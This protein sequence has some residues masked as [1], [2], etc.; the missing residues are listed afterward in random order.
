MNRIRL[1]M[2]MFMGLTC[3]FFTLAATPPGSLTPETFSSLQQEAAQQQRPFAVYVQIPQAKA[4]RKMDRSWKDAALS[5]YLDEH[6]LVRQVN[7]L[8][9]Q[10]FI[11]DYQVQRFPT[12]LI[13]S[14]EGKI[15]G[16]TEGYVEPATLERIFRKHVV[17]LLQR[18][19]LQAL[20]VLTV[21]LSPLSAPQPASTPAKERPL[22]E[23]RPALSPVPGYEAHALP[24]QSEEAHGVLVGVHRSKQALDRQLKRLNRIWR[25]PLWVF[26]EQANEMEVY[27]VVV[28]HYADPQ[29][30]ARFAAGLQETADWPAEVLRLPGGAR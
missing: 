6:Y 11:H 15:M 5:A 18:K 25:G 9:E 14:P 30:A 27:K 16:R 10:E 4:C 2:A 21:D 7:A 17:R 26:G 19:P 22:A 1:F 29:Q 24:P 3:S 13:F 28:G 12:V 23:T 20:P 8:E